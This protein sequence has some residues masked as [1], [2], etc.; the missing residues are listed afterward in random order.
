MSSS[1]R[2]TTPSVSVLACVTAVPFDKDGQPLPLGTYRLSRN[3]N[4][5]HALL[6]PSIQ[7]AADDVG[8]RPNLTVNLLRRRFRD[9]GTFEYLW[10]STVC[11]W[12]E[13]VEAGA[14]GRFG[15]RWKDEVLEK[16]DEERAWHC[17]MFQSFFPQAD[18]SG[19]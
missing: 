14:Y 10:N 11:R 5:F 2:K 15:R 17:G 18:K 6:W 12:I 9:E 7:S 3:P 8:Y 13:K 19:C 16:V 4:W 1:T